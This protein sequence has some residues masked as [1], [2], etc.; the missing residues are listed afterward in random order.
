MNVILAEKPLMAGDIATALGIGKREAG[1]ITLKSGDVVTWAIGHLIQQK[2]PDSYPEYKEW[3]LENLPFVPDPILMEEDP[4]KKDQLKVI[5]QLLRKADCCIIAT[6]P[7]RE[8]EHIARTILDHVG[9]HGKL[10]RLWVDDLTPETIRTGFTKL[11]DASEYDNLAAAAKVRAAADFWMGITATRF[12][13][14][15]ARDVLKEST[16]LAAGRVQTP[17]L[18]LIYDREVAIENFKPM[19]FYQLVADLDGGSG[20]FRGTWFR[21]GPDGSRV[22]RFETAG[23]A[24]A[25]QGKIENR[26]AKVI[27][28]ETKETK[29]H[30]PKLFDKV[31]LQTAARKQLGFDF[32]KTTK[33]LQAVYDKKYCSYPRTSSQHLSDNAADQLADNLR[34]LKETSKYKELFPESIESL[35]GNKRFV[36]NSKATEHHAIVPTGRNP[37]D[38]KNDDKHCL[39][40]DEEKLYEL[41]LRHTLAA[42]HPVGVD[43][44]TEVISEISGETFYSK[45]VFTLKDGWR[46]LMSFDKKEDADDQ[47]EDSGSIP[48]LQEGQELKVVGF[49]QSEGKTTQP[50]RLTDTDLLNMMKDGGR[51]VRE[52]EVDEEVYLQLKEKGIGTPA[53]RDE[54]LEK[55]QK[56]EYI[57]IQKSSIYLTDKGRHFMEMIHDHPLASVELTGEF[58]Q[59]LEEVAAGKRDA[60][61]LQE[62]FKAFAYEILSLKDTIQ[63]QMEKHQGKLLFSARESLG[64]CPE[65]GKEVIEGTKAF[66][67]SGWRDGCAFR[68]WKSFRNKNITAK[69]VKDLLS[70]KDVLLKNIPPSAEGKSAYDVILQL[71]GS[72]LEWAFPTPEDKS[73][74][75]CPLCGKPVVENKVTYGCSGWKEGCSFKIFK[76]FRNRALPPQAIKSILAGKS[77]LLKDLEKANGGGVYSLYIFLKDGKLESRFPTAEDQSLGSCPRCQNPVVENQWSYS[78]SS[79]KEGCAFKLDKEFLGVQISGT[80]IKKLLKKGHTD[81]L[82]GFKGKNG[83]F[84]AALGYDEAQNRYSFVKLKK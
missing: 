4:G 21:T 76:E 10:K 65:C 64:A 31:A 6:D 58:E 49:R 56:D 29:R 45:G 75:K 82:T 72:T 12:F 59:Q 62:K 61:E 53:T 66:G 73:L 7:G 42:F 1:Y 41:I 83:L 54:V 77:V 50:K 16:L 17:T 84:D 52:D 35:K 57:R 20:Q 36:D 70:G 81:E 47:I 48:E 79:R 9:F 33:L 24:K 43:R 80:Q 46:I 19:P 74:G 23:E 32:H 8:G 3:T 28:F 30:A 37:E 78:C 18:R 27:S 13:T 22:S 15:M 40:T 68:I 5:E 26:P 25:I 2:Q 67:C 63:Q 51:L 60:A 55:L 44:E 69:Q 71:K 11:K 14:I 34:R 39:T 38:Y